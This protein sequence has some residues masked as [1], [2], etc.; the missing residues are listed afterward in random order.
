MYSIEDRMS[1]RSAG[2]GS[3][4]TLVPTGVVF[5]GLKV[6]GSLCMSHPRVL[7]IVATRRDTR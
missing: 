7:P 2:A 6:L 4:H 1:A 3:S 5:F